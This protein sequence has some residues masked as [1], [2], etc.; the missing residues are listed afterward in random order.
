[1]E[2]PKKSQPSPSKK[3]DTGPDF[4]AFFSAILRE[5]GGMEGFAKRFV[6]C[7]D[8]T[9]PGSAT[10]GTLMNKLL[11][12]VYRSKKDFGEPPKFD[13]MDEEDIE[14]FLVGIL[15]KTKHDDESEDDGS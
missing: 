12:V 11:D 9:K 10:R 15:S 7:Y 6:E 1:M 13:E 3:T 5:W 14:K 4:D 8:A 2:S